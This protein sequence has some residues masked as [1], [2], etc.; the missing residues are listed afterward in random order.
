MDALARELGQYGVP[1]ETVTSLGNSVYEQSPMNKGHKR[2]KYYK[3]HYDYVEPV[4]VFLGRNRS[5]QKRHYHYIP[6]LETLKVILKQQ[7]LDQHSPSSNSEDDVL[8]DVT[9]GWAI[10]SNAMFSSDPDSLKV[11]LFQDAFEVA[12]PLG[13]AKTKH[14]VL[15]VYFTWKFSSTPTINC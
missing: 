12:N 10:K 2:L 5:G 9:D 3:S 14:K 11:M 4:E 6:I 7:G 8:C 13:S 1:K 15:A